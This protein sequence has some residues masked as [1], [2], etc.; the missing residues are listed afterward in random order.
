MVRYILIHSQA[1]SAMLKFGFCVAG[2]LLNLADVFIGYVCYSYIQVSQEECARRR[3]D[4]PY[5]E[6]HRYNP[7]YLCPS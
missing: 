2:V 5:V 1:D 6:V 3:E 4:V 7:K